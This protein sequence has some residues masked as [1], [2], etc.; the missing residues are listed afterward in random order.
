M[1]NITLHGRTL[2]YYRIPTSPMLNSIVIHTNML[3][4]NGTIPIPDPY[5]IFFLHRSCRI[6][7]LYSDLIMPGVTLNRLADPELQKRGGQI[8]A[9]IFERPFLGVFRKKSAFPTKIVIYLQKFV[10]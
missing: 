3:E 1:G 7:L 4:F 9:E 5:T 2:G 6:R 10:M 8:F